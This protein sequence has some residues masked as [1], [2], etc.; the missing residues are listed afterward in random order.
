[1]NIIYFDPYD[2]NEL[3]EEEQQYFWDNGISLDDW[4]YMMLFPPEILKEDGGIFYCDNHHFE[5]M[6]ESTYG[7]VEWYKIEFRGKE[8]A[9][10]ISYH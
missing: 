3:T 4:N 2:Y 5:R 1:M 7:E 8:Y 6:I 10:G 9:L